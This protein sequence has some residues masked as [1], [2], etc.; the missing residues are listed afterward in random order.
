MP[1]LFIDQDGLYLSVLEDEDRYVRC[2]GTATY[3]TGCHYFEV[4]LLHDDAGNT[5]IGTGVCIE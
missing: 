3:R 1:A 5:M 4:D 2:L